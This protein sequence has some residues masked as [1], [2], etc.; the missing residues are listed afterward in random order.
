MLKNYIIVAVRNL[1]RQKAYSLINILGLAVGMACCILI[2]Q[3][4]RFE[5]AFDTPL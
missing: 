1:T 4:V 5:F 3:Y 2:L